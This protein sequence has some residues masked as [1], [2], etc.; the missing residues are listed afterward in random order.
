MSE[1][2]KT[3]PRLKTR[4]QDE[5]KSSLAAEHPYGE[6]LAEGRVEDP[7]AIRPFLDRCLDCREPF[8]H[9]KEI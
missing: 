2:T 5:I 9:V 8:D 3:T 1:T 4:Y 6:W 7:N